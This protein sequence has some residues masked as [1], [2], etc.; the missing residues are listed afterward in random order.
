MPTAA[1]CT[2]AAAGLMLMALA[3]ASC[4]SV[5]PSSHRV[6]RTAPVPGQALVVDSTRGYSS[7]EAETPA[8]IVRYAYRHAAA[9]ATADGAAGKSS[10]SA[11]L[12]LKVR[13]ADAAGVI[14]VRQIAAAFRVTR[15]T[16][17]LPFMIFWLASD[18]P[19][20]H[21]GDSRWATSTVQGNYVTGYHATG[22]IR[23]SASTLATGQ[24]SLHLEL[25][26]LIA[27]GPDQNIY[28]CVTSTALPLTG[29][30]N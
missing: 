24:P 10:P 18:S 27:A 22:W 5:T 17:V 25:W 7:N 15:G 2:L 21:N 30:G 9:C 11:I 14:A 1:R 16:L 12:T 4:S 20:R 13:S 28:S 19:A 6:S 29:H 8:Y 3:V 26:T 23:L